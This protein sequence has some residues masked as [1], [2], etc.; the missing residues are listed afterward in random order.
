MQ[1]L[2]NVFDDLLAQERPG[3]IRQWVED[4][5]DPRDFVS[6]MDENK[7]ALNQVIN[8]FKNAVKKNV[9]ALRRKNNTT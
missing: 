9:S 4:G 5:K 6:P 8:E 2:R 7:Q 3:M 1:A